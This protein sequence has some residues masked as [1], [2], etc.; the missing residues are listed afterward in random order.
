MSLPEVV[1]PE[2]WT[3]AR[4]RLLAKEKELTR[5]HDALNAERRGLPMVGVGKDY[6]FEGPKGPA[7]LADLFDGCRQLIV[8]HV[9]FDPDWE[10]PCPGCSAALDEVSEGLVRHM[11]SRDTAFALVSRAPFGKLEAVR[12][13]R[14]WPVPWYSSN[15]SDFNYDFHVTLD[16]SRPQLQYNYRPEPD[17]VADE[18]STE[19]PGL[20]CFLRDGDETFHTYSTYARGTEYIGNAYTLLDLTA[21]GRSEDWEEPTGRA[22]RLHGADP[23]FTD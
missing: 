18:P 2:Q 9:M 17:L 19:V 15:G 5:Q 1:S 13:V 14:G 11:R 21:F 3:E 16:A 12:S 20:S 10:A 8:Q 6:A 7:T 22:P 4:V 23:T